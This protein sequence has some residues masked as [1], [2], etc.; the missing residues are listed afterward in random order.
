M[1]R[2]DGSIVYTTLKEDEAIR[3]ATFA[4]NVVDSTSSELKDLHPNNA[5]GDLA[6]MRI[7]TVKHEVMV[8]RERE[9]LL[10]AIQAASGR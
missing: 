5:S 3:Y 7:R 1:A 4:R 10:V 8:A 9:F 6:L 2:S